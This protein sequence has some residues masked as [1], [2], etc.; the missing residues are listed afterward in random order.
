MHDLS[1][2]VLVRIL[3]ECTILNRSTL[4]SLSATTKTH[5]VAAVK[6]V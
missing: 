6:W 4:S 5:L 1:D 3:H 2:Y